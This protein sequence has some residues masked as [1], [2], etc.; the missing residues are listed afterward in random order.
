MYIVCPLL[1]LSSEAHLSICCQLCEEFLYIFHSI[2]F[3]KSLK[4]TVD[5]VGVVWGLWAQSQLG[6][7]CR[8][9]HWQSVNLKKGRNIRWNCSNCANPGRTFVSYDKI[10]PQLKSQ[11]T[12]EKLGYRACKS[13]SEA[14]SE[15]LPRF[16]RSHSSLFL[17]SDAQPGSGETET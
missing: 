2:P 9:E 14:N 5:L 6:Q 8:I 10:I 15:K 4:H 3:L 1:L 17:L 16:A 11:L 13:C 12:L 7:L